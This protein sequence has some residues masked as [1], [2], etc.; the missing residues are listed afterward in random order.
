[1]SQDVPCD[2]DAEYTCFCFLGPDF[3]DAGTNLAN[4]VQ[5]MPMPDHPLLQKHRELMY[6]AGE[7]MVFAGSTIVLGCEQAD[8]ALVAASSLML[9]ESWAAHQEAG[10]VWTEYFETRED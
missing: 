8:V 6:R 5:Q 1:M 2:Q 9:G 4:A 3:T 10:E 7:Q